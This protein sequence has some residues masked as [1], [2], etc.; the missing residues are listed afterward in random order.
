MALHVEFELGRVQQL[1]VRVQQLATKAAAQTRAA[2][3]PG[4][5][6]LLSA[7]GNTPVST[8]PAG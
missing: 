3:G 6:A 5:T 1:A 7:L 8:R 4:G 2:L